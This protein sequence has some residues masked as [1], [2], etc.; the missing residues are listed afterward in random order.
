MNGPQETHEPVQTERQKRNLEYARRNR[1]SA[2]NA[3]AYVN[4]L[5]QKE[6]KKGENKK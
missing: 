1:E 4:G 3:G 5:G 2:Y 6:I